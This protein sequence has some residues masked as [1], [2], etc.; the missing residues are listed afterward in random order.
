VPALVLGDTSA[1]RP[2]LTEDFVS[3]GLT[4]LTAVSGANLTLLLA[5]LLTVA[6]WVGVRGWWL[7]LVGLAGVIMFI[8]LCRTEP[9]VLRAAAM[10]LV[11]LAALGPAAGPP[12]SGTCRCYDD[13]AAGGSVSQQSIGFALSVLACAWDRLVVPA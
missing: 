7:R 2:E 4:H 12:A 5:F 10:G 1:L 11:A 3:T 8:A 9:S 6:R 13:L